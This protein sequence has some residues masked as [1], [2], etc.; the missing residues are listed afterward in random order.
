MHRRS[1]EQQFNDPSQK[2]IELD[3]SGPRNELKIM[4]MEKTS[5]PEHLLMIV[6]CSCNKK[7]CT[8][9]VCSCRKHYLLCTDICACL[10]YKNIEET[11]QEAELLNEI[12][13]DEE[14]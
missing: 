1:T 12:S 3:I 6:R 2:G 10:G 13:E 11:V 7:N 14:F 5:A 4:L 8:S 9:R